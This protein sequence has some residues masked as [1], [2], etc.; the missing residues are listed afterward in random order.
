MS[1]TSVNVTAAT[2]LIAAAVNT[3]KNNEISPTCVKL[4]L[5]IVIPMV[6]VIVFVGSV[7]IAYFVDDPGLRNLKRSTEQPEAMNADITE[8]DRN[9]I[10]YLAERK[11]PTHVKGHTFSS[12]SPGYNLS[13]NAGTDASEL[14]HPLSNLRRRACSESN[15]G[16]RISEVSSETQFILEHMLLPLS[17]G[18]SHGSVRLRPSF[19]LPFVNRLK[20]TDKGYEQETTSQNNEE[21]QKRLDE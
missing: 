11:L 15:T 10:R 21:V 16:P 12:F 6:S 4:I 9:Y 13:I 17:T 14:K 2:N 18:S 8:A 3:T 7:I 1:V 19:P 20:R 5:N